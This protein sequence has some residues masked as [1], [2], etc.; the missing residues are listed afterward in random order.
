[1]YDGPVHLLNWVEDNI[2]PQKVTNSLTKSTYVLTLKKNFAAE[3]RLFKKN[4]F[5]QL[6][7]SKM[8]SAASIKQLVRISDIIYHYLYR[9]TPLWKKSVHS[10]QI[11][12][13]YVH[14]LTIFQ[15]LLEDIRTLGP[16]IYGD[17]P[18]TKYIL[19]EVR[20]EL[21]SHFKVF[22][23]HLDRLAI[24][25]NLKNLVKSGIYQLI[26]HRVISLST[27]EYCRKLMATVSNSF[28]TDNEIFKDLLLL[29][30]FNLPEFYL[31]CIN[32]YKFYLNNLTGLHEQLEMVT[33]AKD[34]L[35]SLLVHN[36][37][38]MLPNIP[39]ISEQL[40]GF[41]SEKRLY[42]KEM[43]KLRRAILRDDQLAKSM[44][45]LKINL[46]VAQFALFI[47]VQIE[48]GL[49][50]KENIGELFSFF[51]THFYTPQTLFISAESLRKKSTDVEFA[52]AQ[53]LKA[54][55]IAML[56]WLNEHYNL[57]NYK[58]S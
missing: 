55:I 53:K 9:L 27:S 1:M 36:T 30:G 52:T 38:K 34:R 17:I 2:H 22:S 28:V 7:F 49:L 3:F 40:H 11:R 13:F 41:L 44:I 21:N 31:Y 24:D 57:N 29:N 10:G 8:E 37:L 50:M 15:G 48:K 54:N 46:P 16:E 33:S 35:N 47:R 12:S 23:S 5:N 4:V 25:A 19:V 26:R 6:V 39:H 32:D 43:L 45:R 58:E 42:I 14:A 18:L 20:W 56:N 51:A